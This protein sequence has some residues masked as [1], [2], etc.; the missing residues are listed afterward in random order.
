[1]IEDEKLKS[2][3]DKLNKFGNEKN[4]LITVKPEYYQQVRVFVLN[5]YTK[6][7]K[8]ECIYV[9]L[10][11]PHSQLYSELKKKNVDTSKIFFIDGIS[12]RI[13]KELK[14]E[15]CYFSDGP[16]A[17]TELSIVATELFRKKK[18]K[19][20]VFDSVATLLT[21]NHSDTSERFI[22]HFTGKIQ[23]NEMTGIFFT[24]SNGTKSTKMQHF[25][26]SQIKVS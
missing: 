12:R 19:V 25:F 2:L 17:L 22:N 5:H 13:K 10:H 21:Y 4:V 7:L 8:Q 1:M 18:Y 20:L 26:D 16:Q 11:T 24:T 15:N 9:T 6:R 3:L 23:L 14:A